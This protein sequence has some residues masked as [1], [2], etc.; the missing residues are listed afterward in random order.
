M[1]MIGRTVGVV[2]VLVWGTAAHALPTVQLKARTFEP[3]PG[4]EALAPAAFGASDIH[5]FYVQLRDPFHESLPAEL[6]PIG[7]QLLEYIPDHTWIAALTRDAAADP[8]VRGRFAWVGVIE[9]ADKLPD[10]FADGGIGSWAF[11]PDG[12]VE[13]RVRIHADVNP[14]DAEAALREFGAEILGRLVVSK[15]FRVRVPADR[16]LAVAALDG[17]SSVRERPPALELSNDSNRSRVAAEVVQASPYNLTGLG[18]NFGVWDGGR[19][20]LNHD[21]FAGRIQTG[22]TGTD[23]NTHATHVTGTVAGSGALS[24]SRGGSPLQWRGMAPEAT[25]ITWDFGGDV[26]EEIFDGSTAFDLDVE[27]NS[28]AWG[29]DGGN[30]STYGNYDSWAPEFDDLVRGASGRTFTVC[31]AATNERDDGDCTLVGGGYGCIPPPCTAKNVITVGA[32]NSNDDSM[33]GFS[34]WGPLDDGRLKPDVTA[35]GCQSNGDGGVMSTTPSDQ[36]DVLCGTSMATPTA[37]GCSAL[38]RQLYSALHAGERP[39]PSLIK[40]ILI[41]T[42][43]DLGNAAPDFAFGH[44]RIDVRASADAMLDDSQTSVSVAHGGV[45]NL[46]FVVPAGL[47]ALRFVAVWDDV[48]G[49]ESASP[50]LVNNVDFVLV[51]PLG[52]THLPWVL[53]PSN[54]S[55]LATRGVDNRNNVE[56]IQVPSPMA[57]A[58]TARVTGTNVPFGPQTV[59]VFGLDT[60]KPARPTGFEVVSATSSSLDLVW[61]RATTSDRRGTLILRGHGPIFWP[62]PAAG[63]S[64]EVGEEVSPG[65]F[66]AFV[67]DADHSTT[68]FTDSGLDEGTTYTYAAYTY[69]DFHNYSLAASASG[70]TLGSVGVEQVSPGAAVF[71]LRGAAPN[72]ARSATTLTFSLAAVGPARLVIYDASGRLVKTLVSQALEPGEYT[73]SWDGRDESQARVSPGVY[74]TILRSGGLEAT[75]RLV[76]LK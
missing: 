28:W 51:D 60:Q 27:N 37:T 43:V 57:G 61:T 39:E 68:A 13:L 69:D 42:S 11:D 71:A 48:P 75:S 52:N 25:I 10:H 34:S 8:A 9:P 23:V 5:H 15:G 45:M 32:T 20:D 74:Y 31:F 72:P 55:A 50:A 62:G 64:F 30:C 56:H 53:N 16:V 58:W 22:E 6:A 38:L 73:V 40:A 24:Q 67:G 41:G 12:R 76:W 66:V 33:T 65:V 21:D 36:Y 29:V 7:V 49:S 19:A 54:P 44:G 1:A 46:P 3:V 70:T 47:P 17:V 4:I 26:P 14:D 2:S 63:A 59:S 35:P 18:V